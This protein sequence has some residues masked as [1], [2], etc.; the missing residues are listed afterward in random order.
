MAPDCEW[1]VAFPCSFSC[2]PDLRVPYI[3]LLA[4]SRLPYFT[5]AVPCARPFD[6]PQLASLTKQTSHCGNPHS[7][8]VRV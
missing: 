8:A 3:Q 6:I 5:F 4:N 7:P 1:L 2:P